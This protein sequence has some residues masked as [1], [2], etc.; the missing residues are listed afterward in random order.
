VII[1]C[2]SGYRATVAAGFAEAAGAT[3]TVVTDD[4]KNYPGTLVTPPT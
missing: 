2:Q 1:H 4:I 3:V